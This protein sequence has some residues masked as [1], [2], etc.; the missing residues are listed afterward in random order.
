MIDLKLK[1]KSKDAFKAVRKALVADIHTTG[2]TFLGYDEYGKAQFD[3]THTPM[4]SFVYRLKK[5]NAQDPSVVPQIVDLLA[6]DRDFISLINDIDVIV[7]IPPSKKIRVIQPTIAVAQEISNRFNK[8]N[9]KR[10][11]FIFKYRAS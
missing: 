9:A 2:S 1:E 6:K 7:P 3:N 4:G 11:Y 10:F 8:P 5:H